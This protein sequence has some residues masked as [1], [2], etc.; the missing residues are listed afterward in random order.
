MHPTTNIALRAARQA[1]NAIIRAYDR[2]DLIRTSEKGLNDYVTNV[3]KDAETIIL[4]TLSKTYP[5]H[6]FIT[7][8]A[9]VLGNPDSDYQWIID[10]LDGTLNFS[11]GIPH[12]SVSIACRLKGQ[13]LSCVIFD[14]VR[15]EEFTA[16]R[17]EG[18]YLNRTRLR[19]SN[20]DKLTSSVVACSGHVPEALHLAQGE[21]IGKLMEEHVVLR[22][23]GSACLDLAWIA[24]GKMDAGWLHQLKHWD[25]AAGILL[26]T[27]AGGLVGDF[28]GGGNHFKTGNLIAGTPRCF[29][30]LT[31]MVKQTFH[32]P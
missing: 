22:Q 15:Q 7:E 10:P 26:L 17:G 6:G 25:M 31:Q 30:A 24:A 28:E 3:D 29:K 32:T 18:A 8:E 27:E 19:V 11:R 16:A 4:S 14:P 9:G 1:G 5:D 20:R 23:S 12:F 2:P 13:L 21:L